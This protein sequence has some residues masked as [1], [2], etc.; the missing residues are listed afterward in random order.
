MNP[1]LSY[2]IG[3]LLLVISFYMLAPLLSILFYPSEIEYVVYFIAI[4][5]IGVF[6][7][8]II[9]KSS[10]LETK[11]D[12]NF[13]E[14]SVVVTV[15]WI[16]MVFLGALPF[17][18]SGELSL[19]DGL[20]ESM[21]GWSTTGLTMIDES[22][23]P[24]ILLLWRSFMQYIGGLGFV[25]LVISSLIGADD[26]DLYQAE[27]RTDKLVPKLVETTRLIIKIY[28]G[29]T[30]LG[31]IM[32]LLA[33]MN[34]FDA[35]NHAMTALSTGGFSTRGAS[36]GYW[37]SNLVNL[38]TIILMLLGTISFVIHYNFVV[39]RRFKVIKDG[40]LNLLLILIPLAI[41]LVILL[42]KIWT[43]F[44]VKFEDIVFQIISA[45]STA[46]LGTVSLTDWHP[47]ALLILTMLMIIGGGMGATA[48]GLK[49]ERIVILWKTMIWGIKQELSAKDQV[50]SNH[51]YLRGSRKKLSPNFVRQIFSYVILYL[52][53]FLIGSFIFT[54][55]GYPV[56]DSMFEYAS[57][58]STIGLSV[59]ITG[60]HMPTAL[61]ILQIITMW[62]GRLE[63]IAIIISFLKITTRFYD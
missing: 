38:V 9:I 63:F 27:G 62:L 34:L 39:K 43:E 57:T 60:S 32:Y 12:I 17:T 16:I 18:L 35:L 52:V 2:Y 56:V 7:G 55:Y 24:K 1:Q 5:F 6:L 61:K 11:H 13:K 42:T 48:G 14:A 3:R 54:A 19:I 15:V 20:F 50:I 21:S 41:S 37:N 40:E 28:F 31:V 47:A 10:R 22:Q 26:F 29:Y 44:I 49:Q 46:G 58:L 4:A 8:Y 53:T 25:V 45:L 36:I 23:T 30:L 51:I 59:G 33:G